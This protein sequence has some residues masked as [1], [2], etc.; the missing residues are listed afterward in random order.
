MY[1]AISSNHKDSNVILWPNA[2]PP[3]V[4]E[5]SVTQLFVAIDESKSVCTVS[6]LEEKSASSV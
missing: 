3:S 4:S 1:I 5:T 2:A 6:L